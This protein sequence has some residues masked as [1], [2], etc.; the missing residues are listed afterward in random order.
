M[1]R[2]GVG[3]VG[4]P[5]GGGG[6]GGSGG[7]GGSQPSQ[8]SS[9]SEAL[10]SL[11]SLISGSKNKSATGP[12][13]QTPSPAPQPAPPLVNTSTPNQTIEG[14]VIPTL[15][16][17]AKGGMG[18][19]EALRLSANSQR[20]ALSGTLKEMEGNAAR[21]GGIGASQ[22]QKGRAIDQTQRNI[23]GSADNIAYKAEQDRNDL[24]LNTASTAANSEQLQNQQRE[25]GLRQW[26]AQRNVE[27][28]QQRINQAKDDRLISILTQAL[29]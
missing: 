26:S 20:D 28:D 8:S 25:L 14:T 9:S 16:E 7:S 15:L 11:S 2:N 19:P 21:Q 4:T 13:N 10:S 3:R 17:R 12:V 22:L 23:A 6:W 29:F 18:A 27:L 5:M 1:P 24:L